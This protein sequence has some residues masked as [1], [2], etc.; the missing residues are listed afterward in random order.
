MATSIQVTSVNTNDNFKTRTYTNANPEVSN[1]K[2]NQFA[3]QIGS[4]STNTIVSV[5]RIDK[6]DITNALPPLKKTFTWT[7][8]YFKPS[9][10]WKQNFI[11][12][13][14]TD[15][16]SASDGVSVTN[17]VIDGDNAVFTLSDGNT[18]TQ[19]ASTVA[20]NIAIDNK[21]MGITYG[22]FVT[23]FNADDSG[24]KF[25]E[26]LNQHMQNLGLL[27]IAEYDSENNSYIFKDYANSTFSL[28][29]SNFGIGTFVDRW[30]YEEYNGTYPT[31]VSFTR[32]VNG[33]TQKTIYILSIVD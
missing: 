1:G 22:E 9:T 23:I 18:V 2:L 3:R 30:L 28:S 32:T 10:L 25:A 20:L 29:I 5:E 27:V 19:S 7:M 26:I 14:T 16:D 17:A 33:M 8:N 31:G 6:D 21:S 11:Y 13:L 24:G 4:L 15:A 12:P